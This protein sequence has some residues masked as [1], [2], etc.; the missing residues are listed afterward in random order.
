ME[1]ILNGN[2][3][4]GEIAVKKKN[5]KEKIVRFK[6]ENVIVKLENNIKIINL[7]RYCVD[8]IRVENNGMV[9]Q[10]AKL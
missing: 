4:N 5:S 10:I 8:N 3:K 7:F 9:L 6:K 1:K 2:D